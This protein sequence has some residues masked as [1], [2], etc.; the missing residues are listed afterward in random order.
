M[1]SQVLGYFTICLWIVPFALFVSLNAND[2]VLPTVNERTSLL[3]KHFR[4]IS[5]LI[6][7]KCEFLHLFFDF[8]YHQMQFRFKFQV[9]PTMTL[10]PITFH[11][12]KIWDCFRCLIM[13]KNQ[14]Y[15][16][17]SKSHFKI[18]RQRA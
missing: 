4:Y 6:L 10:C 3:G 15:R 5:H 12:A 17:E 18:Y 16:I 9:M 2:N 13:P 7:I 11:V 8:S 14:F 1:V